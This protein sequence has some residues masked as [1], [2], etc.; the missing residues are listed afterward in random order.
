MNH[1]GLLRPNMSCCT[2]SRCANVAFAEHQG[3]NEVESIQLSTEIQAAETAQRQCRSRP[4]RTGHKPLCIRTVIIT[5]LCSLHKAQQRARH[6]NN[7]TCAKTTTTG[8]SKEHF[9]KN[10]HKDISRRTHSTQP[11]ST[12][13]C[14]QQTQA[15]QANTEQEKKKNRAKR[16]TNTNKRDT[17]CQAQSLTATV[18]RKKQQANASK[19]ACMRARALHT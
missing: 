17:T 6:T 7:D 16:T 15:S 3:G 13:C 18:T 2:S 12:R 1:V 10:K 9:S 8:D 11:D 5:Q 4:M 14:K 19:Q